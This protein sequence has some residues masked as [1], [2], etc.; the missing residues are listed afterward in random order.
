MNRLRLQWQEWRQRFDDRKKSEKW[1]IA[2]LLVALLVWLYV[3]LQL[4]PLSAERTTLAQQIAS[5][6]TRLLAMQS[7]EQ[8]AIQSAQ[9]DPDRAAND[10][11]AR[12]IQEQQRALGEIEGLAG[13]L[14][15]PY[16]MTQMLTTVL[17][18]QPGLELVRVEN[19]MPEPMRTDSQV[20]G[21]GDEEPMAQ[22][23]KHGL[24]IEM[25]GDY[26]SLL[27]YLTYLEN[28]T[29]RF[30]WDQVHYQQS[31]WPDA[32]IILELHTLSTEEGF[33]GV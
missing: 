17:D 8:I 25:Q 23:Y 29:E 10:R 31:T 1:I 11:L 16:A 6:Q 4:S 3:E 12:L 15:T 7:R 9:E 32:T 5:S 20:S 22:V 27:N 26:F 19:K 24:I 30:F 28:L 13:N 14:V 18:R 21:D 2:T 33:V